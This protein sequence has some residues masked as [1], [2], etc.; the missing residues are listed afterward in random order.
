[1]FES[2]FLMRGL[3]LSQSPSAVAL[4]AHSRSR[5]GSPRDSIMTID[6][7]KGV[8]SC[9]TVWSQHSEPYTAPPNA[10]HL[11][12]PTCGILICGNS[13]RFTPQQVAAR[14][15]GVGWNFQIVTAKENS[16]MKPGVRSSLVRVDLPVPCPLQR[17]QL[18]LCPTAGVMLFTHD[19]FDSDRECTVLRFH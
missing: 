3:C 11:I 14:A 16:V 5:F 13:T 9:R 2:S 4:Y 18:H 15:E 19:S 6:P 8:E 12:S 1:M 17:G 7:S 10:F